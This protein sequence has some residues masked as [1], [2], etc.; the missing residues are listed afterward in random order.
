MSTSI[1]TPSARARAVRVSDDELTVELADG[2]SLSVPLVWFPRLLNATPESRNRWTLLG[3]GEGIHWPDVDEDLSIAG[4]L[5][6]SEVPGS[7]RRGAA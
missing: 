5:A 2:R 3:Q 4:L 1:P 7:P 6:A